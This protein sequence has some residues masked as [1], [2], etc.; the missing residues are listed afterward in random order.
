MAFSRKYLAIGVIVASLAL[1]A[2]ALFGAS[3]EERIMTRLKEL[4]SAVETKEGENLIFRTARLNRAFE[5]A[6]DPNAR[7]S[8]PELPSTTGRKE[9]AALAGG[10]TRFSPNFQ[11]SLGET[12]VRIDGGEARV[13]SVVTLTGT[14]EG[15]LRRDQRH[16]RFS[17]RKSGSDWQVTSI[18]VQARSEDDPE[19]RP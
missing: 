4:A 15:E 10:A 3:D 12:D 1:L 13:V 19:A 7:L 16:V 11:V 5:E 17:L 18:D 2:Y 9:L 6:L 8:A 14:Q